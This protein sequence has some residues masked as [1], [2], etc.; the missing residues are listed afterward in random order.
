MRRCL[1][2]VGLQADRSFWA[3]PASCQW[4]QTHMCLSASQPRQQLQAVVA[5]RCGKRGSVPVG[6]HRASCEPYH[7]TTL[8]ILLVLVLMAG[9]CTHVG[10]MCCS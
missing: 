4:T 7:V 3:T 1:C 2:Q 6:T 10:E 5:R 9:I 8:M